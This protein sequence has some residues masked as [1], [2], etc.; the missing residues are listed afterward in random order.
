MREV[1]E[2]K[3]SENQGREKTVKRLGMRGVPKR[4][5]SKR[6]GKR[7]REQSIPKLDVGWALDMF[8]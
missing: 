6:S 4:Q 5:G 7:G 8:L 2:G 1:T 3:S